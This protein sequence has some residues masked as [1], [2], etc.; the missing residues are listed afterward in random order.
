MPSSIALRGIV[1]CQIIKMLL[2][3]H[4]IISF[5][6]HASRPTHVHSTS[7]LTVLVIQKKPLKFTANRKHLC[8]MG[9]RKRPSAAFSFTMRP[10]CGDLEAQQ[11]HE[12]GAVKP[13]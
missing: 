4:V 3:F 7:D 9:W 5:L 1:F 10:N 6:S 8:W 13:T 11:D 2:T 12:M